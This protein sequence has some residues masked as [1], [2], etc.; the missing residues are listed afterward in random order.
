MNKIMHLIASLD[1]GGAEKLLVDIV[2]NTLNYE[3]YYLCVVNN[4]FFKEYKDRVSRVL[5]ERAFYLE[6]RQGSRNP[7]F[8]LKLMH[9]IIKNQ[10][11]IIHVHNEFS[12]KLAM[13]L[14]ILRPRIKIVYTVHGTKIVTK[15]GILSR[16]AAKLLINRFIVISQAVEKD[17][18]SMLINRLAKVYRIY[19]GIN[20][21]VFSS[22]AINK[23]AFEKVSIC[24]LARYDIE[25]KGQD[26]L[27]NA[28]NIIVNKYSYN[29]LEC[30]F[31]GKVHNDNEFSKVKGLVD[32]HNLNKYVTLN[33]KVSDIPELLKKYDILVLPSRNEGLG[34]VLLEAMAAKVLVIASDL[35]G[36]KEVIKEDGKYGYL[37]S[38]GDI[39]ALADKLLYA[40]K[41]LNSFM[42]TDIKNRAYKRVRE[43]FDI[44]KMI[45]QYENVYYSIQ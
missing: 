32:K 11:E 9:F 13:I 37:F 19:N 1:T 22:A 36:P 8:I 38:P 23:R 10:I 18:T 35:E 15:Y 20:Y 41:H 6:R 2:E 42:V 40:M 39:D 43:I 33:D 16:L 14:K 24:C 44:K 25:K 27:I 21:K 34:L 3:S 4:V 26:L 17:V 31:Y 7:N 45:V 29:S 30:H 5:K 12:K 28:I